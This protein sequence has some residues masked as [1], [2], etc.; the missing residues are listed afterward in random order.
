M[1]LYSALFSGVSGLSAYSNAMGVISDNITNVNTVGYKDSMTMF[2]TL[3]TESNGSSYSPGGVAANTVTNV[4]AQGLLQQ[5]GRDTDLSIDGGGFFVV[6]DQPVTG[7]E[8]TVTFTRAGSFSPD[9]EG[10]LRN[11]AGNYLMGWRL[12]ADGTFMNTG[13]TDLLEPITTAGLTGTASETTR[14]KLRANLQSN[15]AVNPL[16]AT[17]NASASANNMASGAIPAD[18]TRDVQVFDA[19]GNTHIISYSFLRS[20]TPNQWYL[21]VHADPATEVNTLPGFIDGQIATGIVAFQDGRLDLAN[22]SASL[23]APVQVDW[24]NGVSDSELTLDLGENQGND[25]ITQFNS[26]STL[27]STVVD[28][29]IFGNVVGMTVN[30]EGTV[31]AIFDNGLTQDIYKLAL[32]TFPNPDGLTRLQ[33]NNYGISDSSGAMTLVEAGSGGSGTVEPGTLEASTV[34]LAE[35]FSDLIVTQRA[36]SASTRVITTTDEMLSELNTIKR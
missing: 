1:S 28:G 11:I 3:V 25:G 34:D 24:S 8:G 10:F 12:E 13:S 32:G 21:E 23:Q 29:A 2:T 19:E 4:S 16:E 5:T 20:S 35:E 36:Y 6:K 30:D 14:V 17:Y 31:T 26:P 22:T 9:E 7:T 33:A 15:T 27:F 18:F